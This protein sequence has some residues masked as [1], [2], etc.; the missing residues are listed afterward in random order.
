[1][2]R[3]VSVSS[4]N[5]Q[6]NAYSIKLQLSTSVVADYSSCNLLTLKQFS[7]ILLNSNSNVSYIN[8]KQFLKLA[9]SISAKTKF[10]S[11]CVIWYVCNYSK[12]CR[13]HGTVNGCII[14]L[15]LLEG[16]FVEDGQCASSCSVDRVEIPKVEESGL[17]ACKFYLEGSP[18]ECLANCPS[19]SYEQALPNGQTVCKRE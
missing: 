18:D 1:M 2:G 5:C 4:P 3:P 19:S 15:T 9:C 16:A 6:T 14:C 8:Y 7:L 17:C 12:F 10:S 13:K 11:F